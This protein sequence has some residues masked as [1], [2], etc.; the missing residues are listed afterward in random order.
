MTIVRGRGI[1]DLWSLL[2]VGEGGISFVVHHPSDII[3]EFTG[4]SIII[5]YP[6][7]EISKRIE[8]TRRRTPVDLSLVDDLFD[9]DRIAHLVK[10]QFLRVRKFLQDRLRSVLHPLDMEHLGLLIDIDN[11]CKPI[12]SSIPLSGVEP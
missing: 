9:R 11:L 6:L 8:S 1:G 12:F 10:E 3:I 5:E 7:A 2:D 4:E